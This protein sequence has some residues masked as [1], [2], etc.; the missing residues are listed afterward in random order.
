MGEIH[1]S[2]MS[3]TN[4]KMALSSGRAKLF[5]NGIAISNPATAND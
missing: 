1:G 3:M 2:A 4:G 5:T